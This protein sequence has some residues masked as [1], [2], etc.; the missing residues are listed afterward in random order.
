MFRPLLGTVKPG[1]KRKTGTVAAAMRARVL[2][3]ATFVV[4]LAIAA[5]VVAR[6]SGEM[7]PTGDIAIIESYT[8]QAAGGHLLVG[9]YSRF[10]WHHPGPIY[11]YW[12]APFYAAAHHLTSG[13]SAGT[14][15]LAA[16]MLVLATGAALAAGGAAA[17]VA[18]TSALTLYSL[19]ASDLF[20][21]AWNPHAVV[22]PLAITVL[23]AAAAASGVPWLLPIVAVTASIAAQTHIGTLAVALAATVAAYVAVAVKRRWTPL[24]CATLAAAVLWL[25]T[26]VEQAT[27]SPGN[28]SLIWS[29][30]TADAARGQSFRAAFLAWTAMLTAIVRPGFSVADTGLLRTSHSA[31][32]QACAIA[33]LVLLAVAAA[34]AA[35]RRRRFETNLALFCLA[36]SLVALWSVTRIEGEIMGY[37]ILW[38]SALGALNVGAI[39]AG[40]ASSFVDAAP[41]PRLALGVCAALLLVCVANGFSR[42]F[43][44]RARSFAPAPQT[45]AIQIAAAGIQD[46]LRRE[47]IARP[48]VDVDQN[49][50]GLAAAVL[51]QLQKAGIPYAVDDD[52]LPMFTDSARAAGNERMAISVAGAERHVLIHDRP[53]VEPVLDAGPIFVDAYGFSANR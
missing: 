43:E 7:T 20:V 38:I 16:C 15:V 36:A 13:M 39:V 6:G 17:A 25:P 12:L 28:L 23:L 2:F 44:M 51:L 3:A 18:V 8:L 22:L 46:F 49:S 10:Q 11:F 31:I 52:W 14:L 40:F 47:Q 37:E 34:T 30:F 53:G 19:R 29:F 32:L 35:R 24:A 48:F 9:P 27:A 21:S 33:E 50:W 26:F 4:A 5:V 41:A 42:L 45:E 1:G